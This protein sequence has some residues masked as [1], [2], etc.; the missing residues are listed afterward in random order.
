LF[1]QTRFVEITTS[2]NTPEFNDFL[3]K[4]GRIADKEEQEENEFHG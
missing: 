2:F 3:G 1:Q 4:Q